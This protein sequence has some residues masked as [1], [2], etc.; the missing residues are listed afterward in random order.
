[1]ISAVLPLYI[2]YG[3]DLSPLYLGIVDGL[4]QG[5]AALVRIAAG[6]VADRFRRLKEVA[7]FGY[8]LSAIC[9]LG[10]LAASSSTPFLASVVVLDRIGKGIRTAPRDALLSMSAPRTAL[11][12]AF[13]IHRAFD[14][15]GAMLGPLVA[16]ALLALVPGDFD[17]IFIVSFCVAVIGVA[18]FALFV[19]SQK[20]EPS[21]LEPTRLAAPNRFLELFKLA[22]FRALVVVASLLS[23]FAISDGLVYVVLQRR[24][25]FAVRYVPLLY[26]ASALVYML[27]AVP[28]GRLADRMGRQRVLVAGFALMSAMYGLLLFGGSTAFAVAGCVA[29]VGATYA[30]TDGVFAALAS[31]MVPVE[32]RTTGLA[33]L[34]TSTTLARLLASIVFGA[35]WTRFGAERA[36]LVFFV[37][38]IIVTTAVAMTWA[39]RR[40]IEDHDAD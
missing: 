20:A 26:V 2:V 19:D 15:A 12:T 39:R 21:S 33:V 40:S 7:G 27:L 34:T 13:G 30:A 3:L 18:L 35:V 4:Y 22:R 17:L 25:G 28:V 23:V 37:S 24:A 38:L 11:A 9:K 8:G 5:V 31:D 1:M 29:L 36:I 10:L 6:G 32:S 14:T 16:F